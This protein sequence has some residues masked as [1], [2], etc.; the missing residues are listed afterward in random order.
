MR[1]VRQTE[2]DEKGDDSILMLI[3]RW[4]TEEQILSNVFLCQ[5]RNPAQL[6]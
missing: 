5:H 1:G 6:L 3:T 4:E 2:E